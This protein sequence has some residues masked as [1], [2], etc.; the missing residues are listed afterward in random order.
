[1]LLACKL[2]DRGKLVSVQM[3]REVYDGQSTPKTQW[4]NTKLLVRTRKVAVI[5]VAAHFL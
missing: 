4:M 1:M 5:A 3:R 2:G